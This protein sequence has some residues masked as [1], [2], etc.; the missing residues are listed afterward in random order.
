MHNEI[1]LYKCGVCGKQRFEDQF[2]FKCSKCGSHKVQYLQ[3]TT[4]TKFQYF[5]HYPAKV[6]TYVRENILKRNSA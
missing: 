3:P 1:R 4:W 6:I 5:L 2:N